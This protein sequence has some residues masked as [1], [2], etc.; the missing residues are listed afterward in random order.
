MEVNFGEFLISNLD[1]FNLDSYLDV[2]EVQIA[3]EPF[4]EPVANIK[5]KNQLKIKLH[6]HSLGKLF[7]I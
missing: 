2:I 6:S 5:L 4:T 7:R 3:H 1:C